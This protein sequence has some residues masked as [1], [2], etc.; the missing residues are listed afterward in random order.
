MDIGAWQATVH[1]VTKDVTKRTVIVLLF[2]IQHSEPVTHKYMYL[3]SL[4]FF[5]VGHSRVL[6]SFPCYVVGSY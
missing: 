1:K 6:H 4:D 3:H 2:T 5:H